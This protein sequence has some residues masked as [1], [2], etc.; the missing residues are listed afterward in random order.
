VCG[1]QDVFDPDL[2]QGGNTNIV[3]RRDPATGEMTRALVHRWCRPGRSP[4][5][6]AAHYPRAAERQAQAGQGHLRG[7][8]HMPIPRAGA[9]PAAGAEPLLQL[10]CPFR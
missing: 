3:V 1:L 10:L 6:P 2:E 5:D 4:Q 9:L 8:M 7:M